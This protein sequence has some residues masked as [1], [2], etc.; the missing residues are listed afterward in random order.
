MIFHAREKCRLLPVE[1][2]VFF[3][4]VAGIPPVAEDHAEDVF[5]GPEKTGDVVAAVVNAGPVIGPAGS[6][7]ILANAVPV[8]LAFK[9]SQRRNMQNR[10]SRRDAGDLENTPVINRGRNRA[11]T[12]QAGRSD[13]RGG[14]EMLWVGKHAGI[15]VY[16]VTFQ[17]R[18]R[19]ASPC[20]ATRASR[21]LQ[22]VRP[23]RRAGVPAGRESSG[24]IGFG[25]TREIPCLQRWPIA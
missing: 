20:W 16:G 17:T 10:A 2:A 11:G 1:L 3:R 6:E 4:E 18:V 12:T 21:H 8:D 14:G 13:P 25:G 23:P 19:T 15:C 7:D 24:G 22:S 9:N 5:T